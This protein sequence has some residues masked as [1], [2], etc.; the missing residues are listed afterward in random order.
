M[1]QCRWDYTLVIHTSCS[2]VKPKPY[3]MTQNIDSG[4]TEPVS[5]SVATRINLFLQISL[6]CLID[7]L[8]TDGP[9]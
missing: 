6:V 3:A 4:A 1:G 5:P 7:L 2:L 9:A 8:R